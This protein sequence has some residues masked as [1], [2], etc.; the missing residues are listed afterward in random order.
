M[1]STEY[2][3]TILRI[4]SLLTLLLGAC[5][6]MDAGMRMSIDSM[7]SSAN[8]MQTHTAPQAPPT[9]D[10]RASSLFSHFGGFG[11][12]KASPPL[13]ETPASYSCGPSN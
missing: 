8:G 10:Y 11:A 4:G 13:G 12:A 6:S 1:C 5:R 7:R 3:E 9:A 2:W